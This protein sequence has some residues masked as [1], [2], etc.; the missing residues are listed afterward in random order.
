[1]SCKSLKT[2]ASRSI[3]SAKV[4]VNPQL[5]SKQMSDSIYAISKRQFEIERTRVV[6][7][8]GLLVDTS[9]KKIYVN[10]NLIL[11]SLLVKKDTIIK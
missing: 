7:G 2:I 9:T 10:P 5:T 11:N 3:L 1:M 4:L 8:A 6:P